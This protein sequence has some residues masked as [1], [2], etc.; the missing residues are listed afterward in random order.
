MASKA[1]DNMEPECTRGLVNSS[2]QNSQQGSGETEPKK[3][4]VR[5]GYT[6]C[7]PGCYSNTK[8]DQELSFHKFPKDESMK[9][10]WINAI[11][12]K[13]FIPGEHHRVCSLHFQGGKKMG[14][15]DVPAIFPL[16]P[17]PKFRKP[18]RERELSLPNPAKRRRC[19]LS[20][21]PVEN[22][23]VGEDDDD[24]RIKMQQEID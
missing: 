10:K 2:F 16:L 8:R 7:V 21:I 20:V 19:T 15:T 6:C 18:Q 17:Q 24:K 1:S 4:S 3:K 22:A 5:G 11:K 12:R 14:L 23:V 13:D 9:L